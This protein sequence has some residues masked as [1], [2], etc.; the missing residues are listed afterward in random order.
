MSK[1]FEWSSVCTACAT[2]VVITLLIGVM[3]MWLSPLSQGQSAPPR[4]FR[5]PTVSR[6]QVVF[7]F[8]NLL[9]TVGRNGGEAKRLITGL[10]FEL[11]TDPRFSPDGNQIAFSG[12][13]NGN[14]DVYVVSAAGGAPRR[15]T[16]H[17]ATESMVDWSPD[18]KRILFRHD[19][20][21]SPHPDVRRFARQV[22]ADFWYLHI[23]S[24]RHRETPV[25]RLF[26]IPL[27]GGIVEALSL[28][29]AQQGSYSPNGR[30]LA[31]VPMLQWG[32]VQPVMGWKGYR[33]GQT[34]SISLVNL[35]DLSIEKIP[36]ANSN[37]FNP[38]WIGNRVYFLSDRNGATT[39]F[40]YD[41]QT[42]KVSQVLQNPGS[43]LKSASAGPD[44]IVYEQFGSLHLFDL[45][46][47]KEHGLMIHLPDDFPEVRPHQVKVGNRIAS[48]D[49]SPSGEQ[50][51][52]EARGEILTMS[53]EKGT[54]R[55]LTNTTGVMERDPA[56]SPDGK[57]IAY[58]SDASGEY[59]LYLQHPDGSSEIKKF[60]LSTHPGFYFDPVWSPNSRKI[61]FHDSHLRLWYL[62]VTKGSPVLIDTNARFIIPFFQFAPSWSPDSRWLA[63]S[64]QLKNYMSAVFIYSL[65]TAR[66]ARITD[67]M[68]DA[69]S[70]VFDRNGR[71]LYFTAS[72]DVGLALAGTDLSSLQRPISRHIYAAVLQRDVPSP[73]VPTAGTDTSAA[74]EVKIDFDGIGERIVTLP[75]PA[76]NYLGL[77][78]GKAGT[79]FTAAGE[80]ILFPF[81]QPSVSVHRFALATRKEEAIIE[82]VSAFKPSVNAEKLLYKRGEQWSIVATEQ[83]PQ[84]GE[85]VLKTETMEV[86][87]EPRAEW[88]QMYAETWR[89]IR[90]AFY[91]P[92]LHGL[93]LQAAERKYAAFLPGITCRADLNSLLGEMLG[94]LMSSHVSVGG[95]DMLTVTQT[96]E[97]IGLLGADFTVENGRYRFARI[98]T[99]ESWNPDL[100]APL[101]QPGAVVTAGEYLLAVDGHDIAPDEDSYRLFFGTAG[102]QVR[103]KVGPH[104][105]GSGAR[106]VAVTP[107]D[108]END[109]R[110][111]AWIED[112]RRKVDRMSGGRLAYIYL[113]DTHVN[114]YGSFNRQYFA[115]IGKEG[116]VLDARFN[117]GGFMADYFIDCLRRQSMAR[118]TLRD[119]DDMSLP[120]AVIDGPKAMIINE[121][122]GSGGD[123][124][125]W[126]FRAAKLG[127]LI[128]KRTWGGL[129][130]VLGGVSLL[131]GGGIG[132]PNAGFLTLNGTW[133]VENYGV[134][135]DIEVELDPRAWRDGRD[136]QLEKAVE[137]VM[138]ALKKN[139]KRTHSRPP[140][141][142]YSRAMK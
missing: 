72:T 56:W 29:I 26:T 88:K 11:E 43:N 96:P 69:R 66:S 130:M 44:A 32:S 105:D 57:W 137:V 86:Y 100:V 78:P 25:S 13:H 27:E 5:N 9:W 12:V 108:S 123:A 7:S 60:A 8:A 142:N 51:V 101:T 135:P 49:I 74:S 141:P 30:R 114:G 2:P 99:G 53:A 58:F 109:L 45:K 62:D 104:A 118:F 24:T 117:G 89:Y 65:E 82:G 6:T 90:D 63:Y 81:G 48:A 35:A 67:G 129:R 113:P 80:S 73:L 40:V 68:S 134:K 17:P 23:S 93:D 47:Q 106:E 28:P 79:L 87:A 112:N 95:G 84:P 103:L 94:E 71:Y 120:A 76:R 122:A 18:G 20:V 116:I 70:A 46:T 121:L 126:M 39:L 64:R 132:V 14:R 21:P 55:N 38:M 42:R 91:D 1:K 54:V 115:Q 61:A 19:E 10:D 3:V 111:V 15:L 92:G 34:L 33:G 139:P 77:M 140:Y 41:T 128:G 4:L 127:P 119:G 16:Y 124:L 83:S 138:E 50:A 85:R 110:N 52:F 31:Y 102:K 97:K 75:I 22:C 59:Q 131:D 133:D 136:P 37:D 107:V 36:R 98:Y 125:A